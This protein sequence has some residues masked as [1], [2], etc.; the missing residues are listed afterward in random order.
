M[1]TGNGQD[2]KVVSIFDRS[3]KS[4][5]PEAKVAPE[6]KENFSWEEI[7]RRNDEN[8]T[9]MKSEREKANKGV[10]RSYRLKH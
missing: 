2:N 8:R 7:Q 9:R 6:P 1:Q 5:A 10:I 4:A 3:Q